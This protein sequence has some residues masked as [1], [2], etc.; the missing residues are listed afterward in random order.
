[1]TA[2]MVLAPWRLTRAS[3]ASAKC[4][5]YSGSP[6]VKAFFPRVIGPRKMIAARQQR[7]E[8]LAVVDDAADGGAA[9]ADAVI[10]ADAADQASAGA[11]AVELMIGKRHL[12]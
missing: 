9:K 3:S 8:N 6:L 11:L 12:Q 7:A 10:A 2:A 1:M 4:A 5:P